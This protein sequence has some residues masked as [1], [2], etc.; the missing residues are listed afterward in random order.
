MASSAPPVS[1][2]PPGLHPSSH[3]SRLHRDKPGG[4]H[5][6][7]ANAPQQKIVGLDKQRRIGYRL[8]GAPLVSLEDL[9]SHQPQRSENRVSEDKTPP[10]AYRTRTTRKP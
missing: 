10:K 6:P 1:S 4:G 5:G 7:R 9:L 3:Q 8:L 2:P